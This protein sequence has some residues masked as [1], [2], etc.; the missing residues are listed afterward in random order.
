MTDFDPVRILSTLKRH[1]VALVVVGGIAAVAHGSPLV[2]EDVDISPDRRT[3]NLDRLAAALAELGARLRVA[4]EPEGV[5]FPIDAGFLAAQPHMLYL[6]T[7]FG[8]LDL[9][10]TPAGFPNGYDD[11]IGQ[12]ITVDLGD[13]TG[14]PVAS[15]RDVIT[16]KQAAGRL[17]D[18]AALPYLRALAERLDDE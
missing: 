17:K 11:L 13:G 3:E 12:S 7:R 9:M 6:V 5:P 2:T 15:L 18:Q 14:T 4:G 8:D 16:S 1:G 10:L